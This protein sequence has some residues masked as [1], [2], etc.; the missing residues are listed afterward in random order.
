MIVV[1]WYMS[2]LLLYGTGIC[3]CAFCI[4][5]IDLTLKRV[6]TREEF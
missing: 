4:I 3:H 6:Y 2:S 5:I 1:R